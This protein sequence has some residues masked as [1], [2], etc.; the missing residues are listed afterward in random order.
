M[1]AGEEHSLLFSLIVEYLITAAQ[2]PPI[3]SGAGTSGSGQNK[4]RKNALGSRTDVSW[5]HGHAVD[6]DIRKVECKYCSKIYMG[7]A[8]RF[9]HH[10]ACTSNNV[11][12]CVFVPDDFKK[13]MLTIVV[14]SIER[15]S[16]ENLSGVGVHDEKDKEVGGSVP[17]QSQSLIGSAFKKQMVAGGSKQATLNQL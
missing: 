9:K 6:G 10:L 14:K 8:Y 1:N 5:K 3:G 16:K 11:E 13:E 17:T 2:P 7:G 4:K 12:P 15:P